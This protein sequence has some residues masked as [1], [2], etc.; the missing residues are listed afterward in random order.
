M[1][2][3]SSARAAWRGYLPAH[4]P[5]SILFETWTDLGLIG[6]LAGAG[7]TWFAYE[8][9]AAQSPRLAPF[10]LAGL[11]FVTAMGVFGGATLQLWWLT[12]LALALAAFALAGR[13]DF[14]TERPTAPKRITL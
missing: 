14:K 10:W 4:A 6:A 2:S 3:I 8:A 9:A 11:T 5:H 1:A 12:A 13:G 7:L